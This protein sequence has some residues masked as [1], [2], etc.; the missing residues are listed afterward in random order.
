M[1]LSYHSTTQH[2]TKFPALF[3]HWNQWICLLLVIGQ[4]QAASSQQPL[5]EPISCLLPVKCLIGGLGYISIFLYN[6]QDHQDLDKKRCVI[7]VDGF[8]GG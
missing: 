2:Q 4:Q 5:T 6:Y 3:A 1:H 8:M 7:V